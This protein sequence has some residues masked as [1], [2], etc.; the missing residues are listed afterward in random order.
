MRL[1][2]FEG[3]FENYIAMIFSVIFV[4]I[5]VAFGGQA[6]NSKVF[7]EKNKLNFLDILHV[8]VPSA[9]FRDKRHPVGFEISLRG[10][11]LKRNKLLSKRRSI[12]VSNNQECRLRVPIKPWGLDL[13]SHE[14][15]QDQN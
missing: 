2:T 6:N 3:L 14:L 8:H 12:I 7:A 1:V 13:S 4:K 9:V 11:L 10:T 15:D 5:D